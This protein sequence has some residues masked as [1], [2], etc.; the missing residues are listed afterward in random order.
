MI[1]LAVAL[2]E[3]FCEGGGSNAATRVM[4]SEIYLEKYRIARIKLNINDIFYE[5]S[6]W[7]N[8]ERDHPCLPG[9]PGSEESEWISS[10][11]DGDITSTL[12]G[13]ISSL[14]GES[15]STLDGDITSILDG[16]ITSTLDGDI[17]STLDGDITSAL[18]GDITSALDGDITS[19]L[20][21]DITSALDGHITSALDGD[22]TSALDGDTGSFEIGELE[23]SFF[24]KGSLGFK[25]SC[26]ITE[27]YISVSAFKEKGWAWIFFFSETSGD[28]ETINLDR[29]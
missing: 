24:F 19:T 27:V 26:F 14:D 17:T 21:G 8:L 25:F 18:D 13:D 16:D 1:V 22:I 28:V 12:E 11:L 23:S 20:D 15:T 29:A 7:Q 6:T 2:I 9:D 4:I 3:Q 10:I 5:Y